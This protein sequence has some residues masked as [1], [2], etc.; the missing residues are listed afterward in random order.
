VKKG[1]FFSQDLGR[2][3]MGEANTFD[4]I[5][6]CIDNNIPSFTFSMNASKRCYAYWE[7]KITRDNYRSYIKSGENGFAVMTGHTHIMVDIDL[8]H[9]VPEAIQAI[10]MENCGA[11][12]KTPGGYHFW[13]L[14]DERTT[15]LNSRAKVMWDGVSVAGL[16]IRNHGGIAYCHPSCYLKE[17]DAQCYTWLFGN[18]S[19]ADFMPEVVLNHLL[20]PQNTVEYPI[21][22][23]AESC[24][25]SADSEEV[26]NTKIRR[27]L[28]GLATSRAD[29]Y[30]SWIS[31]GMALK[32]SRYPL[33]LWD[34][35]SKTSYKYKSGE[36]RR[37]WEGFRGHKRPLTE[38]SLY[39]WLREDNPH[40]FFEIQA[41]HQEIDKKILSGNQSEIA[42]VF[43][44]MNPERY[45]YSSVT[46][47]Y[48]L[49]S[50]A[51]WLATGSLDMTSI[52]GLFNTIV[53]ECSQILEK[54]MVR[55]NRV[56]PIDVNKQRTV[57]DTIKKVCNAGFIRGV[58]TFLSGLYYVHGVEKLFNEKRHLFAFT[59]GVIDLSDKCQFRPVE[60]TDYITVTCGYP[61]R[62]VVHEEKQMVL[63]FLEK[64]FPSEDVL[65]YNITALSR[66][67]SGENVDQLYHMY[68][69]KGANGKS[70]LMD[71]CRIVFGDYYQT[72]SISY[73]TKESD[74][75][76]RP[77]PELAAAQYARMLVTSEPDVRDRLQINILKNITGNEEVTFRGMYAK[78]VTKYVPQFKVWILLNDLLRLSK[79]D[80]GIARRTRCVE[81]TQRFVHE[82]TREN[83]KLRDDTLTMRFKTEEGWRYGMLGLLFQVH[84][85][86]IGPLVMPK[87]INDFTYEYLLTN[88]PVGA[89]LQDKYTVTDCREDV[90][91]KGELYKTFLDDTH[92]H[93]AQKEFY[94]DMSKNGIS[95]KKNA[96]GTRLY[97]G[98]VRKAEDKKNKEDGRDGT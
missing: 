97:Y 10:M 66:S 78:A 31:V 38:A 1:W 15:A 71:L 8:K 70:C 93:K 60:P 57:A 98:L 53:Y 86:H 50:N 83:E 88:N 16:D 67:L 81:F 29:N 34:E 11:V 79:F 89:W 40:L 51:T 33:V 14:S 68:S 96:H 19:T 21:S 80:N 84:M 22:L 52:P 3:N 39:L 54:I 72:F 17:G 95:E 62:P 61:W 30:Q 94:E 13:F 43:Y 9:A 69:G 49:Q 75:K 74:G 73:L 28:N 91:I 2:D 90:I 82:P 23:P 35:W 25:K 32:H 41:E 5:Q 24:D 55:L 58:I 37:T 44:R 27:V 65:L 45:L 77:L 7:T 47:W 87:E 18:L 26:R 56:L 92:I 4:T 76:D 64:I 42:E 20:P 12:E 36:P 6:Y 85:D 59:N 63:E 48:T 46:G